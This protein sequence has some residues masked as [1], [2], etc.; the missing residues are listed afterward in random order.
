[1]IREGGGY[2]GGQIMPGQPPQGGTSG[3]PIGVDSKGNV[4]TLETAKT[5][6]DLA[7]DLREEIGPHL[8]AVCA[9]MD[10]ARAAGL[11]LD[12]GLQPDAFGRHIPPHVIVTK[13]L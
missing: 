1:M 12:F 13:S 3:L 6:A 8:A 9:V 4:V 11:R 5:D 7:R 10:K 2:S